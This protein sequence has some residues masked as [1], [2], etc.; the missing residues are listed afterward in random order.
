MCEHRSRSFA[1]I[2][3]I[4]AGPNFSEQRFFGGKVI[5]SLVCSICASL[6]LR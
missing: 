6:C 1:G 2:G 5:C 4:L 3:A